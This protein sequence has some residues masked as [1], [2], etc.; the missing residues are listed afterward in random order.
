MRTRACIPHRFHAQEA[1]LLLRE[2]ALLLLHQ[3]WYLPTEHSPAK[4]C[5]WAGSE[6]TESRG[7]EL[8]KI[9]VIS[10]TARSRLAD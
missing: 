7:S 5:E 6:R 2:R 4:V 1:L 8:S 9:I 10:S 3:L